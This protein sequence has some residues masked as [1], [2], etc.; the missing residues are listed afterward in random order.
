MEENKIIFKKN[1]QNNEHFALIMALIA[2][3]VSVFGVVITRKIDKANKDYFAQ[4]KAKRLAVVIEAQKAKIEQDLQAERLLKQQEEQNYRNAM[5][6]QN[7]PEEVNKFAKVQG[8]MDY[9]EKL[10]IYRRSNT[11]QQ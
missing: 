3:L 9:R 11:A 7:K 1:K 10:D 6:A 5:E 4:E 2:L 8:S